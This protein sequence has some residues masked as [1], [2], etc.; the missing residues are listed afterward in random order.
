[1]A[2]RLELMFETEDGGSA[3]IGLDNPIEPAD[4]EQIT[5]VML[6]IIEADVFLARGSGYTGIRGA[7]LVERNVE[8]I[9]LNEA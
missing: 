9:E 2:K 1:M 6:D 5:Q 8:E 3:T 4:P 7:R